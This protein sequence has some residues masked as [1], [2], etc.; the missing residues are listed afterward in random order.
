MPKKMK[1]LVSCTRDASKRNEGSVVARRGRRGPRRRTD[2]Y[3][4]ETEMV[5][6]L[7]E[8]RVIQT[9]ANSC[10]HKGGNPVKSKRSKYF[11]LRSFFNPYPYHQHIHQYKWE[12]ALWAY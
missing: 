7:H 10:P 2:E 5:F 11:V 9:S 3:Y 1:E 4:N 8:D 6:N 12:S